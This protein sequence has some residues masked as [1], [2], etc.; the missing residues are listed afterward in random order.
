MTIILAIIGYLIGS[1]PFGLVITKMCGYD[2]IRTMGSGNIGATNVLRNCSK[3]A[4]LATLLLDSGKGAIAVFLAIYFMP[5]NPTQDSAPYSLFVAI[6][7]LTGLSAIIGHNFPIWLKFKG[8]KGVATTMGVF[9][10]AVPWAGLAACLTWLAMLA[11]FRYSSLSA[12]VASLVAPIVTL[13]VYGVLPAGVCALLTALIWVRHKDNIRRLLS[14]EEEKVG[15]KK[16]G[17]KENQD[18]QASST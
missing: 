3:K 16:K 12:L 15:Q 11:T 8:G 13:F 7:L 4:A 14:G 6:Y 18:E 17:Q 2:D 1:I 5:Y 9:L 10:A